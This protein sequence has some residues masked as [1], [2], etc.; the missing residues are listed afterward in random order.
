MLNIGVPQGSIFGPILFILY[1]NDIHHFLDISDDR[2]L[3]LFADDTHHNIRKN[4]DIDFTNF[5]ISYYR[6][7]MHYMSS[8]I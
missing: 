2:N 7:L 3:I 1:I 4:N 5:T 6:M 8:L